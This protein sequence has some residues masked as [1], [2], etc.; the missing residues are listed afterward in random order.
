VTSGSRERILGNLRRSPRRG[1]PDGTDASAVRHRLAEHRPNTI[2]SRATALDREGR[3]ALFIEMAE[4]VSAT[5]A[6]VPSLDNVPD[7]IAEYLAAH[8]L[9]SR[10]VTTSDPAL[11]RIPWDRR[12]TIERR[13]G[14]A[15]AEDLTGITGAF[16]AIAETGTLMLISGRDSPTRNNFLPD[17]HI[18]VLRADAIVPSYE[19]GW[20]R[21]RAATPAGGEFTMPRT[22][23]F[24]TGPSRTAD[25][26]LKIELGAHGPRRLHIVIVDEARR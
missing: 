19:E 2:P 25:I 11:A 15:G 3:V 6:R 9:P 23:N 22:V 14:I 13:Q 1:A 7:A 12:P 4:E 21:L 17:N 20:T 26:E 16:A 8:N 5:V 24:I 18:V 10:L